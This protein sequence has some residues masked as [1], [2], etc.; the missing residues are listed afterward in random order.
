MRFIYSTSVSSLQVTGVNAP[1][2]AL[3]VNG[4]G[5]REEGQMEL[6]MC[7]VHEGILAIQV[8]ITDRGTVL[9][10]CQLCQLPGNRTD[11]AAGDTSQRDQLPESSSALSRT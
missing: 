5:H 1:T 3:S 2:T 10:T 8:E 11:T 4:T 7:D 6:I 9:F